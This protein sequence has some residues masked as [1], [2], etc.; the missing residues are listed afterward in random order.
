LHGGGLDPGVV[1]RAVHE[2]AVAEDSARA[3]ELDEG[4]FLLFARLEADG[5]AG[6]D[7]EATAVSRGAVEFERGVDLEEVVVA[8]D[9]YGAVA[10][11]PDEHGRRTASGVGPDVAGFVV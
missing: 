3:A 9:L 10:R 5:R 6:G 1:E 7:V 8:A 2:S 4:D 11:V